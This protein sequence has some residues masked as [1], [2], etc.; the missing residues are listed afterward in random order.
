MEVTIDNREK[1]RIKPAINFF[2]KNN[3]VNIAK[4]EVG[5]YLF[6]ENNQSCIFEYKTCKDF[7]TSVNENRIFNQAINQVDC[8]DYHFVCLEYTD[9]ER[10]NI[11]DE[12]WRWNKISFTK[13]QF[14]GAIARLNTYTTVINAHNQRTCFELMEKQ[15]KKCFD[16][17]TIH[18]KHKKITTNPAFNY[19]CNCC[20]GVGSKTALSIVD[21]LKVDSLV[22]LLNLDKDALLGVSGVGDKTADKILSYLK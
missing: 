20:Y 19:L 21:E 18:K 11:C 5:D 13:S 12:L 2:S 16:G 17:R 22:G 15:A 8:A 7:I 4:L 9:V 6:T 3:T 1:H 10:R 14:Y